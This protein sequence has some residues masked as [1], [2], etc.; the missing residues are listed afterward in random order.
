MIAQMAIEAFQ[1]SNSSSRT[2]QNE[3]KSS[4]S[5]S[6]YVSNKKNFYVRATPMPLRSSIGFGI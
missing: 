6:K 1:S 2:Y 3:S 4:S 5:T